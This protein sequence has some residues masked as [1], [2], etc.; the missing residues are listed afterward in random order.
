MQCKGLSRSTFLL[1]GRFGWFSLRGVG[2]FITISRFLCSCVAPALHD[3]RLQRCSVVSDWAWKDRRCAGP[4]IVVLQ[5]QAVAFV[6]SSLAAA[7]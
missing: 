3:S 6:G 5:V 4:V 7:A 2:C 1:F